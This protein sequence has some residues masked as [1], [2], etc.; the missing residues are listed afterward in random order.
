LIEAVVVAVMPRHQPSEEK[1]RK[2]EERI[3]VKAYR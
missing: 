2:G 1:R 3:S